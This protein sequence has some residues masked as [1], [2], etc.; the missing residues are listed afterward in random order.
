MTPQEL[1]DSLVGQLTTGMEGWS[2]ADQQFVLAQL[3]L[4]VRTMQG[5]LPDEM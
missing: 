3:A 4:T 2:V 5:E 1:V